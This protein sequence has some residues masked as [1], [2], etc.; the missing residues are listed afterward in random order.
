MDETTKKGASK[1]TPERVK[2]ITELFKF[3][4]IKDA[5]IAQCFGVS[6][7]AIN[8][9]RNG[10]RWS[11]VTGIEKKVRSN[12]YREFTKTIILENTK[13]KEDVIREEIKKQL[14]NHLHNL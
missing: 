6:R 9:I 13:T 10:H 12:D 4:D 7:E 11:D 2:V 14:I 1:L 3:K 8:T 5:E